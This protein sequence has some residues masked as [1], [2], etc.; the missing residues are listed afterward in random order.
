MECYRYNMT[1][2]Y[3]FM[4]Q[5]VPKCVFVSIH[6]FD[7]VT[8]EKSPIVQIHL[9]AGTGFEFWI[10][11]NYFIDLG[12]FEQLFGPIWK[13]RLRIPFPATV[14]FFKA[15]VTLLWDRKCDAFELFG[16]D[17][18][19]LISIQVIGGR[20][21]CN[22][23]NRPSARSIPGHGAKGAASRREGC[24]ILFKSFCE[25]FWVVIV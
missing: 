4:N 9:V 7:F 8:G 19:E 6:H 22:Q 15:M 25:N 23:K 21:T 17:S 20:D 13:T 18:C 12:F 11:M 1:T 24:G 3:L 14:A 10:V 16:I 5:V 2:T